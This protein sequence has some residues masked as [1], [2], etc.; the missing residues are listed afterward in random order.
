[1][2]GDVPSA[3]ETPSAEVLQERVDK[4]DE[5]TDLGAGNEE[6]DPATA[7]NPPAQRREGD[8]ERDPD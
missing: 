8:S 7:Q 6:P 1:M 2:P 4:L 3:Q 5:K